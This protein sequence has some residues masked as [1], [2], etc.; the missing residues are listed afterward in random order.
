MCLG[1]RQVLVWGGEIFMNL[2]W[3]DR[4]GCGGETGMCLGGEADMVRGG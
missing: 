2:G 1:V 3:L 4:Y